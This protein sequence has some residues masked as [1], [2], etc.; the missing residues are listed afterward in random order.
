MSDS[1]DDAPA[2][3]VPVRMATKGLGW[4]GRES[5]EGNGEGGRDSAP[6]PLKPAPR[7]RPAP[8]PMGPGTAKPEVERFGDGAIESPFDLSTIEDPLTQIPDDTPVDA[9]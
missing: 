1:T 3:E 4:S 6:A 8:P 7:P 2:P 5:G 9:G